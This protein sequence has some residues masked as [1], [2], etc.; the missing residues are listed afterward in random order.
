MFC[1]SDSEVNP[2][3][4]FLAADI[5]GLKSSDCHS[6]LHGAKNRYFPVHEK[7]NWLSPHVYLGSWFAV[8]SGLLGKFSVAASS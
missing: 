1:C 3:A 4:T 5:C 2:L 8:A 7:A 6:P